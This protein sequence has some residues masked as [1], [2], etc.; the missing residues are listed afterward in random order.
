MRRARPVLLVCAPDETHVLPMHVLA[1]ALAERAVPS[2]LVGAATPVEATIAATRRL[3]PSAIVVWA[4]S[5]E[6]A[7]AEVFAALP[8]NRGGR[9]LVAA[10]PG[11]AQTHLPP[12]V[13]RIN[14]LAACLGLLAGDPP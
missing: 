5:P 3:Q 2:R 10:G 4:Q 9:L 6:T 11:W 8:L 12:S 14:S 7:D 1:A 13:T